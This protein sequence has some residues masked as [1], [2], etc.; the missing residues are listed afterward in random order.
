[1]FSQ[2]TE[3][4]KKVE[5]K[6]TVGRRGGLGGSCSLV[7][8]NNIHTS[9][10]VENTGVCAFLLNIPKKQ[11]FEFARDHLASCT[12]NTDKP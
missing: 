1:M 4:E 6:K 8:N 3:S 11:A 5:G 10:A 2:S 12:Y 7:G 9:G